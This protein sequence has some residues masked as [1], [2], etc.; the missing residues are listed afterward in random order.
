MTA[1]AK[2][3]A[4]PRYIEPRDMLALRAVPPGQVV[5]RE[6]TL[7]EVAEH[8]DV[9]ESTVWRWAQ[10]KPRGTGGVV[11]AEYHLSLL[12]LARQ[13]GRKLTA[14]DLVFGRPD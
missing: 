5:R 13:L 7:A 4:R 8:L 10:P 6:F 14:D 11:P 9:A 3:P 2:T 12:R 1:L